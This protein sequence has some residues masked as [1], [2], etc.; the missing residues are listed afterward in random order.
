MLCD[1][2]IARGV[3]VLFLS[4]NQVF[5]GAIPNVSAEAPASPVSEYGR[6]KALTEAALRRRMDQG[7]PLGILRLARVVS[8]AMP[9]LRDWVS[10]LSAGLPITAFNDMT[11]APVPIETVVDV[12]THLVDDQAR[13]IFQLSGPR[14]ISYDALARYVA[15]RVAGDDRLVHVTSTVSAGLP[16]GTGRPHTTLDST[17]L[18]KRYAPARPDPWIMLDAIISKYISEHRVNAN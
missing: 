15:Q 10:L 13:G 9:L 17:L 3:Y 16:A 5:D 18:Q 14:D 1:R 12:I 8:P 6:Q 7:A 2:L 4:T 11:L